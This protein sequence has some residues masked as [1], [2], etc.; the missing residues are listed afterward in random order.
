MKMLLYIFLTLTLCGFKCN[1][2][3][4]QST[5]DDFAKHF[6]I[7]ANFDQSS[8][9]VKVNVSLDKGIHAYGSGETIGRP[10]NLMI[11]DS[12]NYKAIG[13]L[14]LPKSMIKQFSGSEESHVIEG[15]FSLEQKV[16][17]GQGPLKVTFFLQVCSE[18]QC[19][20]PRTYHF[21]W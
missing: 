7:A 21:S 6:R 8:H 14:R 12:G 11:D 4:P 10:V 18:H 1:K 13:P 19:D 15:D 9:L 3:S 2:E 16:S 17:A 20:R 5:I